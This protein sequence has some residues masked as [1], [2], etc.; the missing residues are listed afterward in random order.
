MKHS[1][2]YIIL[3]LFF[4]LIGMG[5][6]AQEAKK[7]VL[8]GEKNAE[9]LSYAHYVY[10][11]QKGIADVNGQIT[12]VADPA[13]SLEISHLS[14]GYHK[15]SATAVLEALK[16]GK[17]LVSG[18]MAYTLQPVTVIAVRPSSGSKE[19]LK[20]GS[21]E[22]IAHDAGAYLQQ[23]PVIAGIRKSS[24]S[25]LDPVLR[26]FKYE[27]LT[28][29]TDGACATTAAC[30]NRMDP[31]TSQISLNMVEKVEV[32]KGPY[33]LR[34]GNSFGGTINFISAASSFT[35]KVKPLARVTAGYEA[36]GQVFR[37]EAMAGIS[38]KSINWQV[39]G[40]LSK[41]SDYHA[42][43]GDTVP[44]SFSRNTIGT[45]FSALL[46]KRQDVKL[47]VQHNYAKDVDFPSLMMDLRTDDAWMM[48]ARHNIRF[49]D[50]QLQ[51][52][53]TS[54]YAT[55]VDH[56]M[57]NRLKVI[58]PRMMNAET[59]AKTSNIGARS[60]AV[61]QKAGM[62]LYTG[63]D[64]KR[65]E[66]EGSRMREYLMGPMAG[67][68]LYDN[69]WQHGFISRYS[70]F[71]E[72]QSRKEA[73]GL[74]VSARLELNQSDVK[75]PDDKF[76]AAYPN[77][78]TSQIN[79]SLSAGLTRYWNSKLNTALWLG[80]TQR[81]GSL[82]ERYISFL[83]VGLDAFEMVGNPEIK[84][85]VNNQ[86]DL[87]MNFQN[88]GTSLNFSVFASVLQDYIS[89][90]KDTTLTP[91]ITTSPGV[92]RFVNIDN[93][94]MT[95][96]EAGFGQLLPLGLKV[97][98]S[99]AYVYGKNLKT[100]KPLAE[101]PPL[102]I[103]LS[104]AGSYFNGKLNPAITYRY[105]SEQDRISEEFGENR[106]PAFSLLDISVDY[107][108]LSSLKVRAGVK[109]LLDEAYYEHLTRAFNGKPDMPLYAPGRNLYVTLNYTLP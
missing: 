64:I 83:A 39:F 71:A 76:L 63:I 11:N 109:N 6:F 34:F 21:Q 41:G 103:R 35:E 14:A 7:L 37:T 90:V 89:G 107:A 24:S 18:V 68:T 93:A 26:G 77:P 33:A 59:P 51:Q 52:I 42:G 30:P 101:I 12:L 47:S 95:G 92:R 40:A 96:F 17:L 91:K 5:L 50:M 38:T 20:V 8:Q 1:F 88:E 78:A 79:P 73:W 69:A 80:R 25:G 74:V 87:S 29:V 49:T 62:K 9:V 94:L 32:Y 61:F 99:M 106:T 23:N 13:A 19:T 22:Q 75:D 43:N 15:I 31:P 55:F 3:V 36:N 58:N 16:T 67:K 108:L 2:R 45:N 97:D 104:V 82:T 81:S 57:D 10:G 102:D 4:G 46:G 86:A 105:V 60:E 53:S 70:L 27:Q 56:F 44:A 48:N 54:A 66:A 72:Y 84:P 100:D 98:L 28:V 65:E 85:E